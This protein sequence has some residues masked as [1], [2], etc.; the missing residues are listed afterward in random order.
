MKTEGTVALGALCIS[1]VTPSYNSAQFIE[2]TFRSV[3]SQGYPNLEY[4]VV[5][6]GSTDGTLDLIRRYEAHLTGWVSEPDRGMYDALNKGFARTSGEIMGWI[7]A[8]DMLHVGALNVVA[9]VFQTFP[10]VEWI[11]GIPTGF[12]EQGMTVGIGK[13]ARWSRVRFLA[14][15]NHW[16]QQESTFW[17]RSLWERAG[18]YLDAS[19]RNG[20]DFELWAR[21]FR[22]AQLYSVNALIGGYRAHADA[23]GVMNAERARRYQEQV[24]ERELALV[25]Y[26]KYLQ[27]FRRLDQRVRR[28]P[29]VRG[30]W[31]RTVMRALYEMPGPDLPPV[32]R[33]KGTQWVMI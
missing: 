13:T 9:S 17:R 6:G 28:S 1:L 8:T 31:W 22:H 15:A 26:G 27:L 2:Q 33:R 23:G 21:F 25:P 20:S 11:T 10:Q 18:S 24:I 30:M 4:I 3:I 14:G 5:D 32:I 29:K 7:S 12:D 16:I 19:Q